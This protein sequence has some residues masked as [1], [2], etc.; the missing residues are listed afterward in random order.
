[1]MCKEKKLLEPCVE[2]RA[3]VRTAVQLPTH[4]VQMK[5]WHSRARSATDNFSSTDRR[6]APPS[7]LLEDIQLPL[8]K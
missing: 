5:S 4:E 3:H 6:Y 2:A 1:M 8:W 7:I